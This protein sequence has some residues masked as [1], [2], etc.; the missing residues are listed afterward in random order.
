[1]TTEEIGAVIPGSA[2]VVQWFG[3]WPDFHDAEIV[4]LSLARTGESILRI[5]PFYPDRPATVVF[6]FE[7]ITDVELGD[8]SGQNV[9]SS[10]KIEEA[11]TKRI[12][13][14]FD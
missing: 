3:E 2:A 12:N 13:G 1:M 7:E 8:F 4:S 11:M 9:I 14:R 6:N 10:L 5:Y